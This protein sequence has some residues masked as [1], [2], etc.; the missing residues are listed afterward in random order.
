MFSFI[1]YT[2][3]QKV[4]KVGDQRILL[5]ENPTTGST[6]LILAKIPYRR[7]GTVDPLA[8]KIIVYTD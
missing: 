2:Q 4:V 7:V 3:I 5:R 8:E 1:F 6:V